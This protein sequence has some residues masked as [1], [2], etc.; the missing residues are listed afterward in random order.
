MRCL[1]VFKAVLVLCLLSC[2]TS[3]SA[4]TLRQASISKGEGE[5]QV[6]MSDGVWKNAEVGMVLNV[7]DEIKTG[8]AGSAELLLDEGGTTG[9]VE[10][11]ENGLVRINTLF[12]DPQT[13]DKVTVLDLAV[14]RVLVQAQKLS[15]ES[16]FEVRTPTSTAGVRGTVFEVNVR[17]KNEDEK[18]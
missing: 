1:I 9:T 2:V 6:K 10:L 11:K 7:N 17:K 14:G 3:L 5:V 8:E 13:G 18:A 15:D 16:K 12:V 4:E